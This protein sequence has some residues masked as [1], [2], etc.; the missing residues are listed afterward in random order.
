MLLHRIGDFLRQALSAL[1]TRLQL[2]SDLLTKLVVGSRDL[3]PNRFL[4]RLQHL[5]R[6]LACLAQNLHPEFLAEPQQKFFFYLWGNVRER[7]VKLA[8][9]RRCLRQLF[10]QFLNL[11]LQRLNEFGNH[12]S[13]ASILG[14][15]LTPRR[16]LC[17]RRHLGQLC[18]IV[19][20]SFDAPEVIRLIQLCAQLPALL[21]RIHRLA[22]D[23]VSHRPAAIFA[24]EL[25]RNSSA[26]FHRRTHSAAVSAD[27]QRLTYFGEAR[28]RLQA[29]Y[30]DWQGDRKSR[31]T[32]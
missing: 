2:L 19:R 8:A 4:S 5:F 21:I 20:R 17:A 25:H 31:T 23:D 6:L 27:D 1:L 24:L 32:A 15:T 18:P 29:G 7:Y 10:P 11:R 28:I 12:G 9:P 14:H 22:V 16:L 30:K 26:Q 13:K 3:L